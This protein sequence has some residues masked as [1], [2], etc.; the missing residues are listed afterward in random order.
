MALRALGSAEAL[1]AVG[2]RHPD[3]RVAQPSEIAAPIAFL[4]SPGA[5]FITGQS[6][7]VDGGYTAYLK[8]GRLAR[9]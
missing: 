8:T 5:A 2:E 3:G 4:C 1:E 6:L 7:V 9:S